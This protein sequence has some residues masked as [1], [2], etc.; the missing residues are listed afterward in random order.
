M[1]TKQ[2]QNSD[3][4]FRIILVSTLAIVAA[5]SGC[6]TQG[7]SAT[8]QT[9]QKSVHVLAAN[10]LA[11]EDQGA[12]PAKSGSPDS[13]GDSFIDSADALPT[14]A[15]EFLDSDGDGLG[16]FA[17]KDED[18]DGTQDYL[19]AAPFDASRYAYDTIAEAEP[20]NT[21]SNATLV[22][23]TKYVK[24]TGTLSS[25]TDVEYFAHPASANAGMY[26]L[27]Y[28]AGVLV[29]TQGPTGTIYSAPIDGIT[30]SAG[31][32][33]QNATQ[34]KFY[35][36]DSRF[37]KVSA[38]TATGFPIAYSIL[39]FLDSDSDGIPDE[40]EDAIGSG[41]LRADTDGDR[42]D[43]LR[44]ANNAFLG[45]VAAADVDNDNIPNWMDR[46]SDGD[47]ISDA[48][49]KTDDPDADGLGNYIDTDSD[50]SGTLDAAD[51]GAVN[52][53]PAD[54]DGDLAPDWID[55][56]DDDDGLFDSLDP[57]KLSPLPPFNPTASNPHVITQAGAVS[58]TNVVVDGVAELSK[59]VRVL[60]SNMSWQAPVIAI[61]RASPG[62]DYGQ[63]AVLKNQGGNT[64]SG[65]FEFTIKWLDPGTYT[66]FLTDG[67][68]VSNAASL[69]VRGSGVPIIHNA[70]GGSSGNLTSFV[71]DGANFPSNP[72]VTLDGSSL[73]IDS[74]TGATRIKAHANAAAQSGLILVT[75]TAGASNP[76]RVVT[77]RDL[78]AQ[79]LLPS[80]TSISPAG[81]H[82]VSDSLKDLIL[83]TSGT[84]AISL[85]SDCSVLIVSGIPVADSGMTALM[86]LASSSD[87]AVNQIT[88][89]ST[90]LAYAVSPY[91][92]FNAGAKAQVCAARS[93]LAALPQIQ[94][95]ASLIRTTLVSSSKLPNLTSSAN[96][97]TY[98]AA[99]AAARQ[100]LQ[101]LA[102]KAMAMPKASDSA[103][104]V[105]TPAS[106]FDLTLSPIKKNNALTGGIAISNDTAVFFSARMVDTRT[107]KVVMPHVTSFLDPNIVQP[108]TGLVN[109]GGPYAAAETTFKDEPHFRD[110]RIEMV[111][112]I[113]GGN[114]GELLVPSIDWDPAISCTA[115]T[116][117]QQ[118]LVP[119]LATIL[120]M[121]QYIVFDSIVA[122]MTYYP[123]MGT[124]MKLSI[125][126][127]DYRGA[128][129]VVMQQLLADFTQ[130]GP[131]ITMLANKVLLDKNLYSS[132]VLQRMIPLV[133]VFLAEIDVA[134]NVMNSSKA[135]YDL[136]QV[137]AKL[138]STV[139]WPIK[140]YRPAASIAG[141][142]YGNTYKI[143]MKITG[144]GMYPLEING[145]LTNPT[146]QVFGETALLQKATA[147]VSK[148]GSSLEF[149]WS[150]SGL[151]GVYGEDYWPR[152]ETLK[153]KVI[154]ADGKESNII[155]KPYHEID[156]A[157][158]FGPFP[159]VTYNSYD[160]WINEMTVQQAADLYGLLGC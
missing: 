108:Q 63:K 123:T 98:S 76:F 97:T 100:Y 137:P 22:S 154:R 155:E 112:S 48:V 152:Y 29:S 57:S 56:D 82:L 69:S 136:V 126:N 41:R 70:T 117:Y 32:V 101:P 24:L 77:R 4:S 153:Y 65:G 99:V 51:Y 66:V 119:W 35:P 104:P 138:K 79:L 103:D 139:D 141:A 9:P 71:I 86:S 18:G 64:I 89:D 87:T 142:F 11:A 81:L 59:K 150:P 1:E 12:Q 159:S 68:S 94:T 124:A 36:G 121:P 95:L 5:V 107:G 13:D 132:I 62:Y 122:A 111:K 118:I 26:T 45:N 113:A 129:N 73:V 8:E 14:N 21:A 158:P 80:G 147:N 34:E 17:D 106:Q 114:G 160:Y 102:A 27:G 43:D 58:T 90:A 134:G 83:G 15:G 116:I 55:I 105:I 109:L 130:K 75:G 7:V 84:G 125:E 16:N 39:I 19:D 46:D 6:N 110:V 140:I 47:G 44:E 128:V 54:N 2:A 31:L 49:E 149:N 78:T 131:I 33:F 3:M 146:V 135:I 151:Y 85:F 157:C 53:I 92:A 144:Y 30:E 50:A 20:N 91:M 42:I 127:G 156:I 28:G 40:V 120:G 60:V 115:R 88:A 67:Y 38:G 93:G 52:G 61:I 23:P 74:V 37:I 10:L 96:I 145:V 72:T 143:T 148:D 133:N 25:T